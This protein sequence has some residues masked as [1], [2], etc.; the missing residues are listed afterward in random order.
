MMGTFQAGRLLVLIVATLSIA[1]SF[2]P[3][4]AHSAEP[5]SGQGPTGRNSASSSS[6]REGLETVTVE[7]T[8]KRE[9]Q[10]Q[11]SHF[12][13]SFDVTYLNDSLERWNLPICPLVA[14]L[15]SEGGEFILARLSQIARDSHAPL[16]PEHCRPNLYVVVTNNPDLLV[17]KWTRRDH[18]M[19]NT[20]NGYGYVRA[21]LHAR[22][23]IRVFYNATLISSD[24]AHRE[25]TTIDVAGMRLDFSHNACI[26]AG[27]AGSRLTYGA[28]QALSAA[29]IV[30]DGSRMAHLTMGQ[31]ADYVSM[32]GL[33]QIRLDANTGTAPTILGLFQQSDSPPQGLS[34]WDR[35]FLEGLYSTDQSSVLQVSTIKARMLEQITGR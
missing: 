7:A 21:F 16:G 31:L 11:I 8:R 12:V 24:G 2:L 18:G 4:T 13:S 33:A 10:R 23:P 3:N 6:N 25:A 30:V 15:S 22:Q 9:L 27:V 14:G 35:S 29:V 20:C 28:V 34:L 32:I 19:F 17:E 26:S 5:S 1:R